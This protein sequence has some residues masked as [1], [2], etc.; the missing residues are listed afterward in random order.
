MSSDAMVPTNANRSPRF[1]M[2]RRALVAAVILG[3]IA[4]ASGWT[5]TRWVNKDH[6]QA[7]VQASSGVAVG[8][9]VGQSTTT[10]APP[11]SG[12]LGGPNSVVPNPGQVWG[13]PNSVFNNPGQLQREPGAGA[14]E[15]PGQSTATDNPGQSTA[16]SRDAVTVTLTREQAIVLIQLLQNAVS[17]VG[18]TAQ[19]AGRAAKPLSVSDQVHRQLAASTGLPPAGSQSPDSERLAGAM[20][21]IF[22]FI[23]STSLIV[24]LMVYAG[25]SLLMAG[26]SSGGA[27]IDI[28]GMK[29]DARGG[30]IAS[31]ACGAV[32][33]LATFRPLID[34]VVA[35]SRD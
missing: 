27:K 5:V 14:S 4:V 2:A 33:L 32:V 19:P 16:R 31:I 25:V 9:N 23:G 34:A 8:S 11:N 26:I 17:E 10:V 22:A 28:L 30:G 20:P 1:R 18:S 13:G 21:L 7:T 15:T 6:S 35:I 12:I 29:I 3:P 24:V